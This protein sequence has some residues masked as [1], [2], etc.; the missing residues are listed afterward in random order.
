MDEEIEIKLRKRG[1]IA[2]KWFQSSMPP[3]DISYIK[4]Q[5]IKPITTKNLNNATSCE[6]DMQNTF[7]PCLKKQFT[8]EYSRIYTSNDFENI[9]KIKEN[10]AIVQTIT[11]SGQLFK[12][13][14]QFRVNPHICV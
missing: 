7:M 4:I 13:T 12:P 3:N 8:P 11:K 6:N 14:F 10:N 2:E 9:R 1:L 5:P